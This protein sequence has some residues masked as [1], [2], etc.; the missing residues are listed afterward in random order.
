MIFQKFMNFFF[1]EVDEDEETNEVVEEEEEVEEKT[2]YL[3][4]RKLS[5]NKEEPVKDQV[6]YQ[7][8][9][10]TMKDIIL[11]EPSHVSEEQFIRKEESS[12]MQFYKVAEKPKTFI[13]LDEP[14]I[15]ETE[16]ASTTR[17]DMPQKKVEIRDRRGTNYEF[18][19]VISPIFGVTEKEASLS[20]SSEVNE[21]KSAHKNDSYLGTVFSPMYG[22]GEKVV[23]NEKEDTNKE[24]EPT[25][26]VNV[27]TDLP[28]LCDIDDIISKPKRDNNHEDIHQCSFFD[29]DF[30]EE[31]SDDLID[32]LEISEF[33]NNSNK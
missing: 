5:L 28:P 2:K 22:T 18:K 29:E 23:S 7:E 27:H 1:E 17:R 21:V 26:N 9:K 11:E 19:T 12:S 33:F 6:S 32:E 3:K 31:E 4:Q 25:S 20:N 16:S 14:K 8:E 30:K 10:T 13:D 24:H 15:Q